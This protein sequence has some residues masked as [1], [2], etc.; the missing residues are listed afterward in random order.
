[1][2]WPARQ[3]AEQRTGWSSVRPSH[4]PRSPPGVGHGCSKFGGGERRI[5][6]WGPQDTPPRAPPLRDGLTWPGDARATLPLRLLWRN[7]RQMSIMLTRSRAVAAAATSICRRDGSLMAEPAPRSTSSSSCRTPFTR[8]TAAPAACI[9]CSSRLRRRPRHGHVCACARARGGVAPCCL[10]ACGGA[11]QRCCDKRAASWSWALPSTVRVPLAFVLLC[12][13]QRFWGGWA[14]AGGW[15]PGPRPQEGWPLHR[16][17]ECVEY[18]SLATRASIRPGATPPP[19]A[20]PSPL[21][22]QPAASAQLSSVPRPGHTRRWWPIPPLCDTTVAIS[23]STS[24]SST[25]V[26]VCLTLEHSPCTRTAPGGAPP[27]MLTATAPTRTT[28]QCRSSGDGHDLDMWPAAAAVL[29]MR[30]RPPPRCGYAHVLQHAVLPPGV[31][32]G[33]TC[34][35]LYSK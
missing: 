17:V 31:W 9:Y 16:T 20:G 18:C 6:G 25:G 14:T 26:L 33:G 19:S 2:A 15:G 21:S 4:R 7:G 30:T 23:D 3:V 27:R 10:C 24:G 32:H 34:Y 12:V 1:M 28:Q 13:G 8:S 29:G 11:G 22:D 5:P 35:L